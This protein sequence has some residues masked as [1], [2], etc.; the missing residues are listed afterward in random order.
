MT[1]WWTP[2]LSWVRLSAMARAIWSGSLSFGLVN[3]PVGLYS[4]TQDKTIH[5]NQ[6][7]E[8]TS[9]RIRYKKVNERTG[10]EVPQAKIVK[11]FNLGDAEYVML[12]D[13][14]LTAADPERSRTISI[15]DF[16]DASD[17]DPLYYR[18]GYYLAPQGDGARRAYALLREAMADESKVAIA[19]LVMRNKEYLVTVRP[20]GPDR[21][22]ILQTMFFSDEVRS[23]AEELPNL[24]GEEQFSDRELAIA[25]QLIDAMTSSWDPSST[26]TPTASGSRSWWRAST[27]ARRSCS[28]PPPRPSRSSTSWPR[29]RRASRRPAGPH[30]R[31]PGRRKQPRPQR[32]HGGPSRRLRSLP[33][34]PARRSA[35][36]R[37]RGRHSDPTR[38]WI[39]HPDVAALRLVRPSM[40]ASS[41]VPEKRLVFHKFHPN[42]KRHPRVNDGFCRPTP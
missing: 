37:A 26:T 15:L 11:G 36:Q 28:R 31:R 20:D 27:R 18:S 12:S 40:T 35:E 2:P 7:E 25:R 29:W 5:F 10:R 3:V 24:P 42:E 17:I 19:S 14:E 41:S 4:A 39:P 9:D 34:N 30:P 13:D 8:G 38:G 1:G 6:F 22:L 33:P 16:V 32:R 23:P 21:V